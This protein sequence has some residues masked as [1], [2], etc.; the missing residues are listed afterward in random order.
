VEI[1]L[2]RSVHA[3]ITAEQVV[4]DWND[5]MKRAGCR[6]ENHDERQRKNNWPVVPF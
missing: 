1:A 4:T 2:C 6:E 3:M 5:I